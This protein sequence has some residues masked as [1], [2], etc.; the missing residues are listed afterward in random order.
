MKKLYQKLISF[1]NSHRD[2]VYHYV[3]GNLVYVILFP[4][5]KYDA[6]WGVGIVAVGKELWDARSNGTVEFKDFLATVLGGLV[7]WLFV[8]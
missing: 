7:V 1:L 4:F 6:I 5:L 8:R 3:A 2:K